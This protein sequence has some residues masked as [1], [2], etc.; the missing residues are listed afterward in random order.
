MVPRTSLNSKRRHSSAPLKSGVRRDAASP[1]SLGRRGSAVKMYARQPAKLRLSTSP[2]RGQNTAR[3]P[4]SP[5]RTP[6]RGGAG[7]AAPPGGGA[8]V[9]PHAPGKRAATGSPRDGGG[10]R[11]PPRAL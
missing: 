2:R 8:G 11:A 7:L 3:A 5:D 9:R 1:I 4:V 10:G 6:Y